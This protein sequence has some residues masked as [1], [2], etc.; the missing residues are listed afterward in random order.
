MSYA[1]MKQTALQNIINLEKMGKITRQNGYQ[2]LLN[3]IATDIRTKH[4][5]RIQ[6]QN[7]LESTR[8]T[9]AQLEEKAE[10]LKEQLAQYEAVIDQNKKT[11]QTNKRQHTYRNGSNY[12]SKK[13][14]LPFTKQYFHV[15]DLQRSG[16][17]PR[18]GSYK[19][20]LSR[21]LEKGIIVGVQTGRQSEK[22]HLTFSSD[23]VGVFLMVLTSSQYNED[24]QTGSEE[25]KLEDLL[26]LQYILYQ[27]SIDCQI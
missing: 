20:S 1:E 9:L 7:E 13:T 26:Q 12:S 10:F 11:M 23:D 8:H 15:R 16:R 14:I 5:R 18:F 17:M 4:R 21:L 6:R 25:I 24:V 22:L 2:D 27:T 3:S 19:Y